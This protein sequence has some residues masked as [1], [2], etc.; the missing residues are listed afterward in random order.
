MTEKVQRNS[1]P[2]ARNCSKKQKELEIS[3]F[4]KDNIIDITDN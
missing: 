1:I 3:Y 2:V 4:K